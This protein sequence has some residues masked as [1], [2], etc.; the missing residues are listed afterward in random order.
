MKYWFEKNTCYMTGHYAKLM[1]EFKEHTKASKWK[2]EASM[3][4]AGCFGPYREG[5]NNGTVDDLYKEP[6]MGLFKRK[7]AEIQRNPTLQILRPSV[8]LAP[9]AR[10]RIRS[11]HDGD[12][13]LD[14][15]WEIKPFNATHKAPTIKRFMH[16]DADMSINC[17][18]NAS[19]I[20]DYGATVWAIVQAL[21]SRGIS[22]SVSLMQKSVHRSNPEFLT[23][24][25]HLVK[26]PLKYTS[27]GALATVFTSNFYRRC[28]FFAIAKCGD[29]Q[30][31]DVTHTLGSPITPTRNV[32]VEG[33]TLTLAI[34][35]INDLKAVE[36]ALE[37][38]LKANQEQVKQAIGE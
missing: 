27:P 32:I 11:E 25:R 14:K 5:W 22:V 1:A 2:L 18:Y 3:R 30:N 9:S 33:S 26:E 16:I 17:M 20:N 21:E 35:A 6:D 19:Q 7:L 13:D 8:Q 36:R 4:N 38:I 34:G 10:K 24:S 12:Y 15:R 28:L 37:Q 23:E 31:R 29:M